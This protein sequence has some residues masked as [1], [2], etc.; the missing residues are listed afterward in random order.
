[1]ASDAEHLLKVCRE[2]DYMKSSG[3]AAINDAHKK[4][5][6]AA[7]AVLALPA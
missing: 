2:Y 4:L 6:D 1:L 7:R 5:L 3:R